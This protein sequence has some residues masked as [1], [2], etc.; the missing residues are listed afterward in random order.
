MA[1]ECEQS[2]K[3]YGAEIDKTWIWIIIQNAGCVRI[4]NCIKV[5]FPQSFVSIYFSCKDQNN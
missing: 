1:K 5:L 3:D 2:Q 4:K